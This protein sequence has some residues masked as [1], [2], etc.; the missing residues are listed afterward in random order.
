MMR[1]AQPWDVLGLS[2]EWSSQSK[3][4]VQRL[5]DGS[6]MDLFKEQK[7]GSYRVMRLA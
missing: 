3:E 7:E 1:N 6:K 4:P 2:R 5:C